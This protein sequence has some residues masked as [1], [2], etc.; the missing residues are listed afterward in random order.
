MNSKT[1]AVTVVSLCMHSYN[2]YPF[3]TPC[4]SFLV[5]LTKD[6]QTFTHLPAYFL[7]YCSHCGPQY[8]RVHV[9]KIGFVKKRNP[10]VEWG[11][12][13]NKT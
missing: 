13:F 1:T 2:A 8:G 3:V 12:L 11:F 10:R 6:K 4:S 9:Y 7:L 5:L